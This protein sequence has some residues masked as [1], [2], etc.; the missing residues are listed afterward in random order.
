RYDGGHRR[1]RTA[2]RCFVHGAAGFFAPARTTPRSVRPRR[3]ENGQIQ[4]Y[5]VRHTRCHRGRLMKLK[6]I[7]FVSVIVLS[8]AV[9]LAVGARI[10][11][12]APPIPAAVVTPDGD[13]VLSGTDI[14]EGQNVWRSMGGMEMGS[15]WGHGSYVAPDWTADA[16]HRELTT[17]LDEWA[18]REGASGYDALGA[19]RQAAL[20][21]RL[22]TSIR[23]NTYDASTARLTIAPERARA[24]A[25]NAAYYTALFRDGRTEYAIPAGTLTDAAR[26]RQLASFFFWAAWA[27]STDR[28]GDTVTYTSNWPHEPLIANRP[29]GDAVVWTGVSVILLLAGI[30][31]MAWW[32]ASKKDDEP[33]GEVPADDPLLRSTP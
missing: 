21:Q 17:I 10:Y 18:R 20:R 7:A 25:Q 14:Q 31:V 26:A 4:A 1:R 15:I 29:T 6:W 33:L 24:F 3:N 2:A 12:Q 23:T 8:F 28:P 22:T 13:V 16:L 9:L 19:E 32:H 5:C 27:A 11:Q 30:G